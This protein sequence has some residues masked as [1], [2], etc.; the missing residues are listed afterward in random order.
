[1]IVNLPHTGR[2]FSWLFLLNSLQKLIQKLKSGLELVPLERGA[3]YH[4]GEHSE[5][6]VF[7]GFADQNL[8][9]GFYRF[10]AAQMRDVPPEQPNGSESDVEFFLGEQGYMGLVQF[11]LDIGRVEVFKDEEKIMGIALASRVCV[12]PG[13]DL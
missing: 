4:I 5:T 9:Y 7:V 3:L 1:M 11:R 12:G 10:L 2:S 8:F 6:L 13:D